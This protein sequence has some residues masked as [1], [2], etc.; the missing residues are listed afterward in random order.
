MCR[1]STKDYNRLSLGL[2][3][4]LQDNG[5]DKADSAVVDFLRSQSAESR[6]WPNDVTLEHA[7]STMPL[8]RVLT[9]GRL[10][11]ILEG[12]EGK[13]RESSFAE[14]PDVP[15]G[16]TIEHVMP[17]SWRANW[18]LPDGYLDEEEK[19]EAANNRS[20]LVHTIGNLTLVTKRLNP[21]L[22]NG[23]WEHKRKELERHSIMLLNSLGCWTSH[24]MPS[25]TKPSSKLAA[26]AWQSCLPKSGQDRIPPYGT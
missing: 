6:L 25:G 21:T 10:R 4:A 3:G 15:R 8:Y 2:A 7:L 23:P 14:Q 9:R 19:E 5:L 18:R 22:S 24:G 20:R 26:R 17:Q 13:L 12:I 1:A 16:L 11:L